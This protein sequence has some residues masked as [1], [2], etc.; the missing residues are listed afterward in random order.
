MAS[1]GTKRLGPGSQWLRGCRHVTSAALSRQQAL[2]AR[3]P[4]LGQ[5]EITTQDAAGNHNF[6]SGAQEGAR[7]TGHARRQDTGRTRYTRTVPKWH[8]AVQ[9][10]FSLPYTSQEI[11]ILHYS[12]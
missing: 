5:A 12:I 6:Y 4:R 8:R 3:Q 9:L 10:D 2:G 7:C 1:G 11:A